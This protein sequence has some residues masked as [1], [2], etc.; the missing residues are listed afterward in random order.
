VGV[1]EETFWRKLLEL[2]Y[3]AGKGANLILVQSSIIGR[4]LDLR[5]T[6]QSLDSCMR[7]CRL[8]TTITHLS[9]PVICAAP[10]TEPQIS[11]LS[12]TPLIVRLAK[13]KVAVVEAERSI[14]QW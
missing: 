2:T 1:G 13:G 14:M 11:K 9:T 3:T 7:T 6:E 5:Y 10:S 4:L 12:V 8:E